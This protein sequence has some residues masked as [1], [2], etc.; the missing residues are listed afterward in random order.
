MIENPMVPRQLTQHD[1]MIGMLR[2]ATSLR[3]LADVPPALSPTTTQMAM[4]LNGNPNVSMGSPIVAQCQ[5]APLNGAVRVAPID[6]YAVL[7]SAGFPPHRALNV[8]CQSV[9]R[10]ADDANYD[11]RRKARDPMQMIRRG[12]PP[13][14]AYQIHPTPER[15]IPGPHNWRYLPRPRNRQL[16]EAALHPDL[17]E[18]VI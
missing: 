11:A 17:V 15:D 14:A 18:Q 13:Y 9:N 5:K 7:L 1:T 6:M 12:L 3:D 2:R 16:L 8:V 4:Y 10:F